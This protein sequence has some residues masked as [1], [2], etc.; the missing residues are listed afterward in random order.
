MAAA[1]EGHESVVAT[2]LVNKADVNATNN[3]S[4]CNAF[5]C[6]LS[7]IIYIYIH[8]S[9]RRINVNQCSKPRNKCKYSIQYLHS[10]RGYE[11]CSTLVPR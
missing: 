5:Y 9:H 2:L 11:C 4:Y 3:V 7:N 6:V 8:I 1:E 10:I